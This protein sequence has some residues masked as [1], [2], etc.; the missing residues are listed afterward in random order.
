MSAR[1]KLMLRQLTEGA[2]AL[3]SESSVAVKPTFAPR[4]RA[5]ACAAAPARAVA[6]RVALGEPPALHRYVREVLRETVVERASNALWLLV[7]RVSRRG[8]RRQPQPRADRQPSRPGDTAPRRGA[9]PEPRLGAKPVGEPLHEP[10]VVDVTLRVNLYRPTGN[11]A[12]RAALDLDDRS[13]RTR[14]GATGAS[15]RTSL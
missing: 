3:V 1:F 6:N 7:N 12:V 2:T 14:N 5:I 10:E 8:E 9:V 13:P 11:D 4:D 15:T